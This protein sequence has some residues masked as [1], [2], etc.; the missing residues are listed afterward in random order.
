MKKSGAEYRELAAKCR[1]L[2]SGTTTNDVREVLVR[3]A[4]DYERRAADSEGGYNS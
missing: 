3:S 2:A 1:R 4:D